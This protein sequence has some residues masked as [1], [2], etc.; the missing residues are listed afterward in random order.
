M[1]CPQKHTAL[2]MWLL[3][4]WHADQGAMAAIAAMGVSSLTQVQHV[5][6][7]M[8]GAFGGSKS[9]NL[10]HIKLATRITM[11]RGIL[12]KLHIPTKTLL[13][14]GRSRAVLTFQN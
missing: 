5:H 3:A 2:P 1:I 8:V 12:S 13:D 4:L 14:T 6:I 10:W 7:R 11:Y 9:V